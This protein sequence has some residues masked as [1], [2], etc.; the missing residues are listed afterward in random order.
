M[1]LPP[2]SSPLPLKPME[3]RLL[4]VLVE[5]A[6]TTPNQYP[7]SLNALVTGSNQKSN[8]D[9]IVSYI[10]EHVYDCLEQLKAKGLVTEVYPAGGR[11]EKF[12]QE[13]TAELDLNGPEKAVLGELL[14]RGAQTVGELRGR[15]SRMVHIADLRALEETLEGLQ[16]REQPLVVRLTPE[17]V[18]R[19]VRV[20]HN[21]YLEDEWAGL[22]AAEE[23]IAVAPA[24]A[25]TPRSA[26]AAAAPPGID[27]QEL[28]NQVEDLKRRVEALERREAQ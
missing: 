23:Q 16:N 28:V 11:T 17:G 8:R 7:L 25:V 24:A 19:G 20:T 9:P 26:P 3:R 12:R 6:L 13:L 4:G 14:L 5:K 27:L 2:Q 1:S 22:L 18:K 15:A 10:D 21:L